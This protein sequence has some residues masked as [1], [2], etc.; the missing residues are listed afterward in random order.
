MSNLGD[1]NKKNDRYEKINCE[2]GATYMKMNKTQHLKTQ[3]HENFINKNKNEEIEENKNKNE[4]IEENKNLDKKKNDRNEKIKCE[5]GMT[6]TKINKAHHYKS[7]NHVN[8]EM[9][10]TIDENGIFGKKD[11]LSSIALITN[12]VNDLNKKITKNLE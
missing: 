9:K 8:Y 7:K 3:K 2:C 10:K 1:D 5:C 6:Y 12:L 4:E 11:L